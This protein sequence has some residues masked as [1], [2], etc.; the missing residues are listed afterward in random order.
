MSH[1]GRRSSSSAKTVGSLTISE[2]DGLRFLHFGTEWIQGAMRISRPF[3]IAVDYVELMMAWLLLME[4]PR[5]VLQLGLGAGSLSKY[6]W[7]HLPDTAT[8]AVDLSVEVIQA[9][10]TW[11]RL[12]PDDDRLTVV[13]ADARRF[14]ADPALGGRFGV[15]QVDL[16]DAAARGPTVDAEDFYR[17]CRRLLAE[18]GV[19]VVNLFGRVA[20]GERSLR[21]L[22][23]VFDDR[24][25]VLSPTPSG[26]V[27]AIALSGPPLEVTWDLV[28]RRMLV[29]RDRYGID[30]RPLVR[31]LM[32]RARR[33]RNPVCAI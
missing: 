1:A 27:I 33:H 12:P 13:E 17:H 30:V 22:R 2:E 32:S 20:S 14:V 28:L 25:I 18:P 31:V 4:P 8:T 15:I 7:R 29:V 16:Y 6:C 11:F 19:L 5:H 24:L 10:R 21:R 23:R 9:A 3:E 26:N